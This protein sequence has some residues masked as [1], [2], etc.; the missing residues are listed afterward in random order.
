MENENNK[1]YSKHLFLKRESIRN[2][3]RKKYNK[4]IFSEKIS[5]LD[6]FIPNEK[7]HIVNRIIIFQYYYYIINVFNINK[8]K[9]FFKRKIFLK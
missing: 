4:R 5:K 2:E 1:K 9:F 6:K 8:R 7:E 3:L